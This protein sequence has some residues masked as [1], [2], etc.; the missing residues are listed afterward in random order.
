[1]SH[2]TQ[3]PEVGDWVI[4][5]ASMLHNYGIYGERLKVNSLDCSEGWVLV[6][7]PRQENMPL[8]SSEFYIVKP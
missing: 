3:V 4:A 1:M 6:S 5:S 2:I 8:H 7:V